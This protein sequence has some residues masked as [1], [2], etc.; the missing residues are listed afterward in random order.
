[1][2]VTVLVGF[3][4]FA[5]NKNDDLLTNINGK[6]EPHQLPLVHFGCDRV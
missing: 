6:T 1:M 3:R 5:G 2:W 4:Y